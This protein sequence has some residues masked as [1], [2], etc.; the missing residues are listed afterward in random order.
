MR[1]V[2]FRISGINRAGRPEQAVFL[3][4]TS[5]EARWYF[6]YDADGMLPLW[7]ARAD[8]GTVDTTIEP[9]RVQE[10]YS[11][12]SFQIIADDDVGQHLFR[13]AGRA[14][15]ALDDGIE[16]G[17]T[18]IEAGLTTL[19]EAPFDI[20][21]E[22]GDRFNRYFVGQETIYIEEDSHQGGGVYD[23]VVRGAAGS[24]PR[25]H[26]EGTPVFDDV[27]YWESR[28]IEVVDWEID[29]GLVIRDTGRISDSFSQ[30]GPQIHVSIRSFLA[31]IDEQSINRNPYQI[32]EDDVDLVFIGE[33]QSRLSLESSITLSMEDQTVVKTH[34]PEG[35]EYPINTFDL[36]FQ[37]GGENIA[38][39]LAPVPDDELVPRSRWSDMGQK[40]LSE[41]DQDDII[42]SVED[43]I[44]LIMAM[45]RTEDN[46]IGPPPS[47]VG[48]DGIA[49]NPATVVFDDLSDEIAG[50]ED[51]KIGYRF[52]PLALAMGFM[53]STN[54]RRADPDTFDIFHGNWSLN[55]RDAFS[56]DAFDVAHGLIQQTLYHQ[57][58]YVI[59]GWDG[60]REQIMRWIREV[61]NLYGFRFGV[62]DTGHLRP[63]R[64]TLVGVTE[65]S[66]AFDGGAVEVLESEGLEYEDGSADRT[67]R[68]EVSLGDLPWHDG[69]AFDASTVDDEV[70][71]DLPP[72]ALQ[73]FDQ[74]RIDAP[75]LR[76]PQRVF[77][78]LVGRALMQDFQM[79]RLRNL[80]VPA[81]DV[82]GGP[83]YDV[84]AYVPVEEIPTRRLWGWDRDGSRRNSLQLDDIDAGWIGLII[85]RT[86]LPSQNA[87]DLEVLFTN[88]TIIRWRAP[89]GIIEDTSDF[90]PERVVRLKLDDDSKFGSP[91]A[92][93]D[94]F[95]VGDEVLIWSQE[96]DLWDSDPAVIVDVSAD[97]STITLEIPWDTEPNT[98]DAVE[99]AHLDTSETGGENGYWNPGLDGLLAVIQRA[100]VFMATDD[101][102]DSTL[103]DAE[104][105]ADEYGG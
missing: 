2:G 32:V 100:Y 70:E 22:S 45:V 104:I 36:W 3:F 105:G 86:Y 31:G 26:P 35:E 11:T 75:V 4:A 73:N 46:S 61:M 41:G 58:D 44:H 64:N 102:V 94:F 33:E 12:W 101:A 69:T 20:T 88:D 16:P 99:L 1:C 18:T 50:D 67:T 49:T 47:T 29:K 85:G 8:A 62:T 38:S 60:D 84:G 59:L 7:C 15:D 21:D 54:S 10:S 53:C 34:D 39:A 24:E 19:D 76:D 30:Q 81:P 97:G 52:H 56:S 66:D 74:L 27:P 40:P 77:E 65:T 90:E 83:R 71:R 51:T 9:F 92:D 43:S 57:V 6:R 98:G 82:D 28:L 63:F 78:V 25:S 89:S 48:H 93:G 17:D 80:R 42:D 91:D 55:Q 95:A 5:A 23:D 87:Y 103:G 72:A 37:I 14:V 68:I 96:G 79:P 13:K